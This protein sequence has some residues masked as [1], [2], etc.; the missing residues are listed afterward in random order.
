[1]AAELRCTRSSAQGVLL[2]TR[3]TMEAMEHDH[4]IALISCLG[5]CDEAELMALWHRLAPGEPEPDPNE[6]LQRVRMRIA[7]RV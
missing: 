6:L 2:K 7:E 1:M 5:E 4:L 3:G